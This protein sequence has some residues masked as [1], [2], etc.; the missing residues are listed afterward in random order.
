M[1]SA[2][3]VYVVLFA[4]A[5]FASAAQFNTLPSVGQTFLTDANGPTPVAVTK[6]FGSPVLYSSGAGVGTAVAV[7]DVNGDGKLDVLMVEQCSDNACTMSGLHVFLGNGDGTFHAAMI[8]YLA[9]FEATS[10]AVADVNRDGKL[11]VVVANACLTHYPCKSGV[12]GLDVVLGN[13][14]G[15]FGPAV[16]YSSGGPSATSVAIGD[17]N[18]DG[19]LDLIVAN[20]GDINCSH[21]N[22]GTVAVLAGNGDGTFQAAVSFGSGGLDSTGVAVADVNGDG[23]LDLLVANS[24]DV[25]PPNCFN[26]IV[27][28]LLGHG[29]GTFNAPV[30]YHASGKHAKPIEVADVNGDGKLDLLVGACYGS[31]NCA[32][33]SVAVLLGNGDGTFQSAMGYQVVG[34]SSA[35]ALALADLNGDGK[36]DVLALSCA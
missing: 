4:A 11:D 25:A 24:C 21:A 22:P 19:K 17:V 30:T 32:S 12:G 6:F 7:A 35:I 14:D 18:R 13:G 28:V 8:N 16:S 20:C 9:G 27:S 31:S 5:T 1:K 29:D 3:V 23:N 36:L 33:G 15:T 10:L 2:R 26:G 34:G